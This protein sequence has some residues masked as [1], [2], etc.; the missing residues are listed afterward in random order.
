[1]F[2]QMEEEIKYLEEEI[3]VDSKKRNSLLFSLN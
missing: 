2:D 3:I 1:M